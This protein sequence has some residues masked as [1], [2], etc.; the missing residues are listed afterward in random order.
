MA[1]GSKRDQILDAALACFGRY[2]F[3]RTSLETI[4]E[5]AGVSRPT[6]YQHFKGK[7]EIFRAVGAR[8]LEQS[9]AEAETA[10]QGSGPLADRLHGVLCAKFHLVVARTSQDFRGELMAEAVTIA[11]DLLAS[12]HH[13]IAVMLTD[14]LASATDELDLAG[15]ALPAPEV[16]LL[17]LDA[18][19]GIEQEAAPVETLQVRLQQLVQLTVRGLSRKE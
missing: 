8:M 11:G 16:A 17:L 6:V 18:V 7:A 5:T 9:L 10:S 15:A 2:S 1:V 14:L 3:R 4:A 19:T 13:R 12:Y